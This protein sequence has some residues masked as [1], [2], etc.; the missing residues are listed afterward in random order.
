MKKQHNR[1]EKM[2]IRQYQMFPLKLM[3]YEYISLWKTLTEVFKLASYIC[4]IIQVISMY[5]VILNIRALTICVCDELN[6]PN[7]WNASFTIQIHK[8]SFPCLFQ[9]RNFQY[10]IPGLHG[11]IF[12]H[13]GHFTP[14]IILKPGSI[15]ASSGGLAQGGNGPQGSTVQKTESHYIQKSFEDLTQ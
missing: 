12:G 10:N 5:F 15:Q 13:Q 2:S 9:R 1:I 4:K 3:H 11:T 14:F 8:N 7:G 6:T